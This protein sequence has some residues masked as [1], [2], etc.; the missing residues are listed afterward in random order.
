MGITSKKSIL[1]MDEL[2]L[3]RQGRCLS[4]EYINVSTKLKWQCKNGHEW[5]AT[6][7]KIQ[8]GRWCPECLKVTIGDMQDLAKQRGGK[9][10]SQKY[11]A[12]NI[13]LKWQCKNNHTWYAT[14]S[15]IKKDR[16][17]S[18]CHAFYISEE[19]TRSYFE[20]IFNK[21]FPKVRDL[22][23]LINING[24]RMEL[25]GYCEELKLAFEYQGKQ[26]YIKM[27][28]FDKVTTLEQRIDNDKLK[29]ELCLKNGVA[30]I[31]VPYTVKNKDIG[32]YIYKELVKY[33]VEVPVDHE[34]VKKIDYQK[35]NIYRKDKIEDM[36]V[37]AQKHEGKCLS[38]SYINSNTKL[39]W[40]CNK[41]HI[42]DATPSN[43]VNG[44]RWCP[45]CGGSI[46]KTLEDMK[47][48]A[49]HRDGKCLSKE[50]VNIHTKLDWE[51][52]NN[53]AWSAQPANIQQGHWCPYCVGKSQ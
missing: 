16:W 38:L 25:D 17:C 41:G 39:R 45:V 22:D 35:F 29:R 40:E 51:C 24:N 11:I 46:K 31:D 18:K 4:V 1:D 15:N 47:E 7:N 34:E 9:C 36:K 28:L 10:L 43:V 32:E 53:H 23:F 26:H 12:D 2:A 19:I 3:K 50:Y 42:W 5:M 49:R 14:P 20:Y 44:G 33:N 30:L 6:P 37:L 21:K 27:A 52:N 13:K 48:M 8:Q